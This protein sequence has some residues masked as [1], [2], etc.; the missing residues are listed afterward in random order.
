MNFIWIHDVTIECYSITIKCYDVTTEWYDV[1]IE[2]YDVTIECHDVTNQIT[3]DLLQQEGDGS[4]ERL[5]LPDDDQLVHA[6]SEQKKF[7]F[8]LEDQL[9]SLSRAYS[10]SIGSYWG[11]FKTTEDLIDQNKILVL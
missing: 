2:C 9:L 1:T 8:H 6:L 3:S 4:E 11:P 10:L 7:K 5:L